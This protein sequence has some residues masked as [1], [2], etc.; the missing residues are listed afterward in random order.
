MNTS[1]EQTEAI[2]KTMEAE[3]QASRDE[4]VRELA[5]VVAA[6]VAM[7]EDSMTGLAHPKT[8]RFIPG[9]T[10]LELRPDGSVKLSDARAALRKAGAL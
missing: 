5:G 8:G 1:A 9:V 10:D 6:F 2:R 3:K 7:V 4:L